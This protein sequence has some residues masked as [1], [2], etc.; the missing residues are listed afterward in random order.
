MGKATSLSFSLYRN[1]LKLVELH[2]HT[3]MMQQL[4]KGGSAQTP[5]KITGNLLSDATLVEIEGEL[6][7]IV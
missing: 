5:R 7:L 4:R 2:V 6:S 1:F 3:L